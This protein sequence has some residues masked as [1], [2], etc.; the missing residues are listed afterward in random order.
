MTFYFVFSDLPG[1]TAENNCL[2]FLFTACAGNVINE[3]LSAAI[4]YDF[5]VEL[6]VASHGIELFVS[7]Y[8]D[9]VALFLQRAVEELAL[10]KVD[11][12]EFG[13][14][15]TGVSECYCIFSTVNF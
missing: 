5:S 4:S 6:S 8:S 9:K 2:S 1:S 14:V 7:G 15:Q 11:E 13:A 12:E 3:K 10:L